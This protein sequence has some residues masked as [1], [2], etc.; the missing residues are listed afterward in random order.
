MSA[1]TLSLIFFVLS[2]PANARLARR[3]R[4]EFGALGDSL[5][6]A[7]G[8]GC[9]VILA[10]GHAGA[11]SLV[12][13]TTVAYATRCAVANLAAPMA[14]SFHF[15]LRDLTAHLTMGGTII[16]GKL[17]DTSDRSIENALMSRNFGTAQLGTYSIATQIASFLCGAISNVFWATL[18]SQTVRANDEASVVRSFRRLLR[19]EALILFPLAALV[20]AEGEPLIHVFLGSK[21]V[22]LSP[23]L[24][25]FLI[26]Y[27]L[28]AIGVVGQALLYARG[29]AGLQFRL[30]VETAVLRVAFVAAAPWI[31]ILGLIAGI[32]G[33]AVYTFG[34][35]IISICRNLNVSVL[36][37]LAELVWPAASSITVGFACWR[38][39]ISQSPSIES[40]LK[41]ILLGIISYLLII[42]LIERN[43]LKK[44]ISDIIALTR[45]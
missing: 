44:D 3:V 27:A 41:N 42:F 38:F 28:S 43:A 5:G 16:G 19:A 10:L 14:P 17:V 18:Y 7:L 29:V 35:N 6:A 33:I 13:Q 31:G 9:A 8:A 22:S 45:R 32:T 37:I 25:I 11:W 1:L 24:Q 39:S 2:V 12:A 4:L 40:I 26:A 36:S 20:A 23:M 15:S 21:W 30:T 34:R